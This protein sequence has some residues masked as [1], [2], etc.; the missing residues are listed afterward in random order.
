MFVNRSF[1]FK[2]NLSALRV[3]YGFTVLFIHLR[4]KKQRENN[5]K[6]LLFLCERFGIHLLNVNEGRFFFCLVFA[7]RKFILLGN[8]R[9]KS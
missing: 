5:C 6:R 7:E 3:F 2:A 8:G 1:A 9:I 4:R